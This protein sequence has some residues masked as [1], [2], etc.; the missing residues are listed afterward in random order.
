LTVRQ[1]SLRDTFIGET[2]D[3]AVAGGLKAAARAGAIFRL[4]RSIPQAA[5][6]PAGRAKKKAFAP[7]RRFF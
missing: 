3:F 6:G 7:L 1:E 5:T 2:P 4:L